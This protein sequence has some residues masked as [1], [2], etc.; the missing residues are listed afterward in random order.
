MREQYPFFRDGDEQTR[1]VIGEEAI[2]ADLDGEYQK[3][4][5][6]LTQKRLYCKNEQGN[7]IT[8]AAA[9][10]SAGKGLLPGQNWFLWAV[11]A[12][13]SLLLVL[14]C[15][16]YWGLDG[17]WRTENISYDAQRYIDKYHVFEEQVKEYEE[18]L[19]LYDEAQ[20][21]Q[22]EYEKIWN[23]N[24]YEEIAQEIS[25]RLSEVN[26]A[27]Q[28]IDQLTKTVSDMRTEIADCEKQIADNQGVIQSKQKKRQEIIAEWNKTYPRY[29]EYYD[30]HY[31]VEASDLAK[32]L[33][34]LSDERD[35]LSKE[36]KDLQSKNQSLQT[37][38]AKL[39]A[40]L[41]EYQSNIDETQAEVDTLRGKFTE[42]YGEKSS[43]IDAMRQNIA[44]QKDIQASIDCD[45]L[46]S[47]IQRFEDSKAD[48]KNAQSVQRKVKLFLPCLLVFAACVVVFIILTALKRTKPAVIAAL[49]SIG[50]GLICA[51]L[52]ETSGFGYYYIVPLSLAVALQVL[53][54]LAVVLVVLALWWNRKQTVFQIVHNAGAFSFTPSVYPAEELRQFAEQVRLMREG[55][56]N[57]E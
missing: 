46:K 30:L 45:N 49:A 9:L 48:Y 47:E 5:A 57:G 14:L 19:A 40:E 1:A 51:S 28:K 23:D 15:L 44:E 54:V 7:F 2:N 32:K 42:E 10:R 3:P 41:P 53:R 33:N 17:R 16:W 6:V 8:D 24:G 35:R 56:A 39:Q 55:E 50:M 18:Q 26:S 38:I 22:E 12:C 21:K 27:Q 37:K 31:W 4:Y 43:E 13:V 29:K 52:S 11:A 25:E 20:G 36:I 34:S